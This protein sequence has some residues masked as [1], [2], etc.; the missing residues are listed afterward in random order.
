MV[1]TLIKPLNGTFRA[2]RTIQCPFHL[3]ANDNNDGY[4]ISSAAFTAGSDGTISVDLE[5]S[6]VRDGLS[7]TDRYPNLNGAVALVGHVI[8]EYQQN[9]FMVDHDPIPDNDHHGAA[10]TLLKN[11]AARKAARAMASTATFIVDINYD[12]AAKL[13]APPLVFQLDQEC[14]H[15]NDQISANLT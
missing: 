9:A 12:E 10:R 2:L 4:R 7:V 3:Q 13:G 14:P 1:S 6:L 8:D 11:K 15:E 5:E